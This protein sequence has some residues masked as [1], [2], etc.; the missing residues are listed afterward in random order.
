MKEKELEEAVRHKNDLIIRQSKKINM[1]EEKFS[2]LRRKYLLLKY[3]SEKV[4]FHLPE[5]S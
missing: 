4:E 3:Y 2:D 5:L 1:L